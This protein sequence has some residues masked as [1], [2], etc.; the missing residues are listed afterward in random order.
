MFLQFQK[1]TTQYPSRRSPIIVNT[2][3]IQLIKV[4]TFDSM[5]TGT[6]YTATAI[7]VLGFP[8]YT[9]YVTTQLATILSYLKVTDIT[10][11]FIPGTSC[12]GGN[13]LDI[14]YPQIH[15]PLIKAK[16]I[17]NNTVTQTS[18]YVFNPDYL[19]YAEDTIFNDSVTQSQQTALMVTIRDTGPTGVLTK[20]PFADL[21]QI[22]KPIQITE[23]DNGN[24]IWDSGAT[25]FIS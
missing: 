25:I 10:N 17:E 21:V 9:F 3:A 8:K 23:W 20:L 1:I 15:Y 24:T 22:L 6:P 5:E 4:M 2:A 11:G 19:L 14:V 13:S 7:E 12:A 16:A 18:D